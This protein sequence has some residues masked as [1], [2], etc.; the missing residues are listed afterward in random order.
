MALRDGRAPP[1]VAGLARAAGGAG[2]GAAAGISSPVSAY[3][4]WARYVWESTRT[5][6]PCT[7]WKSLGS[8]TPSDWQPG[9]RLTFAPWRA[10]ATVLAPAV[11]GGETGFGGAA[12]LGG[13]GAIGGAGADGR[14]GA[15]GWGDAEG[16][17]GGDVGGAAG[18]AAGDGLGADVGVAAAGLGG[19]GAAGF[20]AAGAAS[21][22]GDGTG[23]DM[24]S[25]QM[26]AHTPQVWILLVEAL[27]A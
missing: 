5:S 22:P 12:G 15:G 3:H 1:Q 24:S 25:S 13:L 17:G 18:F 23:T 14:G 19:A 9:H 20:G 10:S 4:L 7:I 26:A 21:G 11:D 8:A 16:A 6:R 27:Q 2:A